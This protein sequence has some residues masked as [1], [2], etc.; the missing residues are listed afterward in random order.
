MQFGHFFEL[1]TARPLNGNCSAGRHVSSY[2]STSRNDLHRLRRWKCL[3]CVHQGNAQS[4]SGL[5]QI[6][7]SLS[8]SRHNKNAHFRLILFLH[9]NAKSDDD[10][11]WRMFCIWWKKKRQGI[12]A[13]PYKLI[14]YLLHHRCGV[15]SRNCLLSLTKFV[16]RRLIISQAV[17]CTYV[18]DLL[19]ILSRQWVPCTQR[20]GPEAEAEAYLLLKLMGWGSMFM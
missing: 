9:A 3:V 8:K 7:S 13:G 6:F 20:R 1:C 10:D 2:R 14:N 11:C 19:V 15:V 4:P 17:G 5:V 16:R 12:S 18:I